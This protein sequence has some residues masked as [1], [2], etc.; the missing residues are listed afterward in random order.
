MKRLLLLPLLLGLTAPAQAEIDPKVREACLPAADFLG[1]VKAMTGEGL[2]GNKTFK[3]GN[4]CPEGAAY[5]GNGKCTV[6][7]CTYNAAMWGIQGPNDPL[8]KG[9][10]NWKCPFSPWGGPGRLKPGVEVPVT[11][12]EQCPQ[13]EPAIGWNSTCEAPYI[14]KVKTKLPMAC[15]NGVWDKDH[16]KCQVKE[17]RV[18]SPMDMD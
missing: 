14:K 8:L 9:K 15:R 6:V 13:G 10:S 2:A 3:K 1:C 12:S 7:R 17:D 18:M 4:K 16:P 5:I 11:N